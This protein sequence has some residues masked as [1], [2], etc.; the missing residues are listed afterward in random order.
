M[1]SL[2][3]NRDINCS[4]DGPITDHFNT[5]TPL[6]CQPFTNTTLSVIMIDDFCTERQ[7]SEPTTKEVNKVAM[8]A[9]AS[10]SISAIIASYRF[11]LIPLD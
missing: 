2:Y 3:G 7:P 10:L 11:L 9:Y 5:T 8:V 1:T 4:Y 6:K